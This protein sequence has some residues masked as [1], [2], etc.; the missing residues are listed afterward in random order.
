MK[1]KTLI[2]VAAAMFFAAQA[3]AGTILFQDSLTNPATD[4]TPFEP[5]T[6]ATYPAGGYTGSAV[7]TADPLGDGNAL[8]FGL[9]TYQ[10]DIVTS[11]SFTSPT[12]MYSLT[13]DYLGTCGSANGCGVVIGAPTSTTVISGWLATDDPFYPPDATYGALPVLSDSGAWQQVTIDFSS[14]SPVYI[15]LE[16]YEF[17]GNS[18]PDSAWYKDI[19]LSAVPAP[20]PGTLPL[21]G[22]GLL[23]LSFARRRKLA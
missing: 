13:F 20:E 1:A 19:V 22:L 9:T 5:V 8:T 21:L 18:G 6:G 2:A 16:D 14:S 11:S 15:A 12:G 7:I 3:H 4:L 17:A 23:G 10:G